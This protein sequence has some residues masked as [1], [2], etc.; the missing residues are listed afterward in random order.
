MRVVIEEMLFVDVSLTFLILKMT[1][2]ILRERNKNALLVSLIGG[3]IVL[4][5]PRFFAGMLGQIISLFLTSFM[6]VLL[7][8]DAYSLKELFRIWGTFMISTFVFGGSALFL[9]NLIG[10]YPLFIVAIVGMVTYCGCLIVIKS[11]QRKNRIKDFCYKVKFVDN[12]IEAEED[13]FLDSG[14]ML[15]DNITK[16]PVILVSFDV[17]HKLYSQINYSS[18]LT[19]TFDKSSIKNGHYIKINSIGS[20]GNILVFSVDKVIV[21]ENRIFK[22]VMV[23]LSLS[24]FEKSFGRGVLLHSELV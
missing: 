23:G 16:K 7:S 9:Q 17:F 5:F 20:G 1:S 4:L 22:N 15:Y 21:G 13:G 8:F 3:E 10:D 11:V 6:L 18:I 12:G 2:I 19:K 14:N 24:G